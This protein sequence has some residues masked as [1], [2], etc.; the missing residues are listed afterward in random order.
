MYGLY[1]ERPENSIVKLKPD[2][3][4]LDHPYRIFSD[5]PVRGPKIEYNTMTDIEIET[6]PLSNLGEDILFFV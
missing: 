1:M 5:N 3:V 4:I 2:V 6:L